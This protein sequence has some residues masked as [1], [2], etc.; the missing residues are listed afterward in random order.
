MKR[1]L[2]LAALMVAATL[3]AQQQRPAEADIV[4]VVND[5]V[6]TIADLNRLY[7]KLPK[8]MRDSYEANG[9][10]AQFLEQYINK[11]LLVQE[12]AKQNFT[13]DP[14]VARSLADAR[15]STI[16]DLYVRE[17]IADNVISEAELLAYYEKNKQEFRTSER[18]KARHI[19]ATPVSQRVMNTSGDNA[20][21]AAEALKK[22]TDIHRGITP[23]NF[24]T[25]ALRFSEDGSA[26][27]SGDLGWFTRGK[28][29]PEFDQVAFSLKPGQISEPFE[30]SFGWHIVL[31]EKHQPSRTL[32]FE[33]TRGEILERLLQERA[34]KVLTEVNTTTRELRRASRV[35]INKEALEQ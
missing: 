31:V 15:E 25:T 28:M 8:K 17:V 24:A 34:D 35:R 20:K 10:K 4:A 23:Q 32:S 3:S 6:I 18:I 2:S 16:F 22:I 1:F 21:T 19:L 33:E 14:N 30:T 12:A 5:D 7:H 9:G 29:V 13:S 26:P 27:Q 11:R